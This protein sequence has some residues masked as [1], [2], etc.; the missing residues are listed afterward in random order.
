V[1]W[2]GSV[3]PLDVGILQRAFGLSVECV[4]PT[5]VSCVPGT[6][7]SR[8]KITTLEGIQRRGIKLDTLVGPG[9]QRRQNQNLS[10]MRAKILPTHAKFNP[11]LYL[12]TVHWVRLTLEE[13]YSGLCT[14]SGSTSA[15]LCFTLCAECF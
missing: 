14:G 2:V 12:G 7:G 6:A 9:G 11:H 13:S 15:L 5:Q 10:A 4:I 1:L 3:L 8:K